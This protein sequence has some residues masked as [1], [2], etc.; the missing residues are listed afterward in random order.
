MKLTYL[1]AVLTCLI[2]LLGPH[3]D[4]QHTSDETPS[5]YPQTALDA[6]RTL[7]TQSEL[8]SIAK[9]QEVRSA[10][11]TTPPA[12]AATCEQLRTEL[13][14]LVLDAFLARQELQVMEVQSLQQ[15]AQQMQTKLEQRQANHTSIIDRRMEELL[16]PELDWDTKLDIAQQPTSP[17]SSSIPTDTAS[18]LER[19]QGKWDLTIHHLQNQESKSDSY[20]AV[21]EGSQFRIAKPDGTGWFT[22]LELQF[23]EG[24]TPQQLD[25]RSAFSSDELTEISGKQGLVLAVSTLTPAI[26]EK[27]G[28]AIR[29]CATTDIN[30]SRP[31]QFLVNPNSAIYDLRRPT[32]TDGQTTTSHQTFDTPQELLAFMIK[33]SESNDYDSYVSLLTDDAARDLA[34]MLL[35]GANS[36]TAQIALVTNEHGAAAA[37]QMVTPATQTVQEVLA[38]WSKPNPT[39]EQREVLENSLS[40]TLTLAFSGAAPDPGAVRAYLQSI[41]T[42]AEQITDHRQ[43]AVEMMQAFSQVG[44]S[45]PIFG[46]SGQTLTSQVQDESGDLATVTIAAWDKTPATGSNG[47]S[48][49]PTSITQIQLQRF[50]GH[51]LISNLLDESHAALF[52]TSPPL[53]TTESTPSEFPL[54]SNSPPYE[55]DIRTAPTYPTVTTEIYHV[56]SIVTGSLFSKGIG[57]VDEKHLANQEAEIEKELQS[58]VESITAACS[59]APAMIKALTSQRK[60]IARH[61]PEGQQEI[62]NLLTALGNPID[63]VERKIRLRID[64]VDLETIL[65]KGIELTGRRPTA[66]QADIIRELFK[67][68]SDNAGWSFDPQDQVIN[69]GA[70]M[71]FQL[72]SSGALPLPVYARI[73]PGTQDIQ[74][75]LDLPQ[76]DNRVN[77]PFL[78]FSLVLKDGESILVPPV[79]NSESWHF[80]VTANIVTDA[81]DDKSRSAG[82]PSNP[83]DSLAYQGKP[84]T[85][86]LDAYWAAST[87][88]EKTEATNGARL[89]SMMAI[90]EF[91]ERPECDAAILQSMSKWS[92]SVDNELSPDRLRDVAD[93]IMVVAGKRHQLQALEHLFKMADRMPASATLQAYYLSFFTALTVTDGV[94]DF[95]IKSEVKDLPLTDELANLLAEK[96][97]NGTSQQRLL[98]SALLHLVGGE[99]TER[100]D[101]TKTA[102][103]AWLKAQSLVLQPSLLAA[104]QDE[105]D[106]V[107]CYSALMLGPNFQT[108]AVGERLIAMI[109]SDPSREVRFMAIESVA[110]MAHPDSAVSLCSEMVACFAK[111]VGS[112]PDNEIRKRA[113]SALAHRNLENELVHATLMEWAHSEDPNIVM[114]ALDWLYQSQIWGKT[115]VKRSQSVDELIELLSDP[116]WGTQVEVNQNNFNKHHRWARQYA[117]AV[118]GQY[119]SHALQALPILEA[120]ANPETLPFARE[121]IDKIAGYCS[122]LPA[123]NLQGKWQL[124]RVF[125]VDGRSRSIPFDT[126]TTNGPVT[127]EIEG[128]E[129]KQAGKFLAHLSC[130][131][132][133]ETSIR[134]VTDPGTEQ[135]RSFGSIEVNDDGLELKLRGIPSLLD[136]SKDRTETYQLRRA[137]PKLVDDPVATW[138]SDLLLPPAAGVQTHFCFVGVE[139]QSNDELGDFRE[140]LHAHITDAINRSASRTSISRRFVEVALA[141]TKLRPDALLVPD[142]MQLFCSALQREGH[143]AD[144]MLLAKI[145]PSQQ[146]IQL[147]NTDSRQTDYTLELT[148]LDV[149]AQAMN[150]Q[151]ILISKTGKRYELGKLKIDASW[152]DLLQLIPEVGTALVMV[153]DQ[154]DT[155]RSM[156]PIAKQVADA[157]SVQLITLPLSQWPGMFTPS[158]THFVLMKD[159]QLVGTR[160][161]L[162]TGQRLHDFVDIAAGWLTPQATGVKENSLVRIDCYINPGK[163]NIGSQHGGAYP[164]TTAVVAVCEDQA[165]LLGPDGIAGYIEN[166]YACEAIVYDASGSEK[167]L[168]LDVV[169]IGPVKLIGQDGKTSQSAVEAKTAFEEGSVVSDP[170][171][172]GYLKSATEP[173]EAYGTGRAIYHIRGAHSLTPVT[174][175]AVDYL[176]T[177]DQPVLSGGFNRSSHFLPIVKFGAPIHWQSQLANRVDDGPIYGGNL[178][179][180]EL[181]DVLC[182]TTPAPFGF[183]FNELGQLI[184]SYALGEPTAKD[185]THSVFL[186]NATH[187]ILRATLEQLDDGPLKSALEQKL[188]QTP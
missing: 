82:S 109:E 162:M 21:I 34:G 70:A 153:D 18:W 14:K 74:L 84:V 72:E 146:L 7:A 39:A 24:T 36:M 137:K 97:T 155:S 160:S 16:N 183:T 125:S 85:Y 172:A 29:I 122:D 11:L 99:G 182:P 104:S 20:T 166:G 30:Q 6:S 80:L 54:S 12:D 22:P 66:E 121:A 131:R 51:W 130:A 83:A 13:R 169:Q 71:Q 184:G 64:Y 103:E 150:K 133:S 1:M 50:N 152:S 96:I 62:A 90:A 185:P 33:C 142:K 27:L 58:L 69:S 38:R 46:N 124:Q 52:E 186:P 79:P 42:L 135:L 176:P 101:L 25:L 187:S 174:L 120:E 32:A 49:T 45:Y 98:A 106:E 8:A 75:R 41:R 57:F 159:R 111:A 37:A 144:Y 78:P 116:T 19:L 91:C 139:N 119:E 89:T 87:P 28:E 73:M 112:D 178:N 17:E 60:L 65:E 180:P 126:D 40:T 149:L 4:A 93:C 170:E 141:E 10:L 134:V 63:S 156:Q 68:F 136:A 102:R 48:Y 188:N 181:F 132:G 67:G 55:G 105:N 56:G 43:F 175:A 129:L 161:G 23:L 115:N 100:D 81:T 15:K 157:A 163:N 114:L 123:Q 9:A 173:L 47:Q 3:A 31:T 110:S 138:L 5:E 76:S 44:S 59:S 92:A 168:P 165:L 117:I 95:T 86:W 171:L 128:T 61:T 167:Q 147:Q 127:V 2:A 26:I 158:A 53:S 179:G 154:S 151:E 164:L 118:L 148:L 113:L 107:R 140:E 108:P 145:K 77:R 94:G 88:N 143:S 177:T 35:L